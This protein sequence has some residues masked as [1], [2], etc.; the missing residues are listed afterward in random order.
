MAFKSIVTV[1]VFSLLQTVLWAQDNTESTTTSHSSVSV[2][3]N[4]Q[5]NWYTQPWVW[6]VGA[7]VFILLLIA[8]LR[9]GGSSASRTNKVT[10]TKTVSTDDDAV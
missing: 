5:S 7:A 4:D 10:Y 8:L 1:I 9:G 3:G 2:T 6:I